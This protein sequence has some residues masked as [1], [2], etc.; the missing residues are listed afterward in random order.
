MSFTVLAN[1]QQ[2]MPYYNSIKL[3]RAGSR[4]NWLN[5]SKPAFREPSLFSCSLSVSLMIRTQTVRET[6]VYLQLSRLRRLLARESFIKFSLRDSRHYKTCYN[7]LT[8]SVFD[9]FLHL[10]T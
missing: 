7:V 9:V 3:S 1:H 2:C 8:V 5:C 6:Q 10:R 4:V